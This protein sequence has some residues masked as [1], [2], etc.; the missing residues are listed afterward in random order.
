MHC[1]VKHCAVYSH[2]YPLAHAL[3]HSLTLS[4]NHSLTHSLSLSATHSFIHSLTLALSLAL[5][6]YLMNDT[7]PKYTICQHICIQS[8]NKQEL[9]TQTCTEVLTRTY[10]YTSIDI[11]TNTNTRTMSSVCM[12]S[13]YEEDCE[14]GDDI[15]LCDGC[16]A[17]AHIRCLNMKVV[18]YVYVLLF[19]CNDTLCHVRPIFT[20]RFP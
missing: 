16:N 13:T 14:E 8:V 18:C 19:A 11:Y 20:D 5:S 1:F 12:G 10:M 6:H 17:E 4:I 15:I 3:I 7:T 2:I 9:C